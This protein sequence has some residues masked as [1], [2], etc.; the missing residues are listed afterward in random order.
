MMTKLYRFLSGTLRGRLILGVALVNAAMMALLIFDLTARQR[1]MLLNRQVEEAMALSHALALSAAGWIASDDISGL[2]ELVEA[3]RRYPEIIFALLAD[4]DGRIMADTDNRRIGQ[5]L[6]D[7]PDEKRQKIIS[8]SALL[9]DVVTPAMIGGQHVGWARVGIGQ[10]VAAAKLAR[11]TR[12][13]IIYAFG[14]ILFGSL[15]AWFLGVRVTS[16]LYAVQ[17]TIDAVRGG[18]RQA[19]SS[20]RGDDEAAVM[21]REF[22]AMLDALASRDGELRSSEERFR[23]LA[24]NARDAIYRMSLPDGR[25]EYMSPA[26]R[27]VFGHAPEEFYAEPSL[28]RTIVHPDWHAYFDDQWTRL[29]G[30]EMPPTYEYLI[31]HPDGEQHWLNQRNILVRDDHGGIVAIE[32]VVTDITARKR[33]E[34]ELMKLFIA[35]EQSPVSIVITDR[36]GNI[37]F[38]NARFVQLT[39]YGREEVLGKNTRMFK[40][41]ETPPSVYRGLWKTLADGRVWQ[42]EFHNR[43][44]NGELF[45]EAAT[46]SPMKNLDGAITHYIAIK[47]DVTERKKLEVQLLQAQKMEAVGILAGGVAHDFNN[48]L[49]AII[50]FGS[51]LEMKMSA[52]DPL[53]HN[54]TQIL[55]AA[56]RAAN[57][58]RSLLAFSRKQ[59]IEMKV[60]DLNGIVTGLEKMLRRLIREDIELTISLLGGGMPVLVDAGQI[61]QVIINLVV[62]ARDAMPAG[63]K[64]TVTVGRTALDDEFSHL[65]GYGEPG[66]YA[67]L[68]IADTG[69]GMAEEVCSRVFD[70]FFTTKEVGKGTGLGLS[71]C[72]GIVKQH[73]GYINCYSELGRGTIFRIYLPLSGV[74]AE[75]VA[76]AET[77]PLRGGT[78]TILL[79]EDD[80]FVRE[81]TRNILGEF[82]YRVLEACD[83]EDAVE[84]F[85][86]MGAGIDLCLFD[87]IMPK[88]K[89]VEAFTRIRGLRGDARVLFMSGYQSD[90]V[91]LDDLAKSG[92]GFIAK[93]V[94]PRELLR[95]I[96]E[97]LDE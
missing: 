27:E 73:G 81:L 96:R 33:T 10:K 86:Q 69:T 48:I 38:V 39:G 20:L 90:I 49:T 16:R 72:Y 71:V 58:T 63:G 15:V 28:L 3:Q 18:D 83:G 6:Q 70:P 36:G 44:K 41:G 17:R 46:I 26:A 74:E 92:A 79:A 60:T 23:R 25:Y 67:L 4:H 78:E 19:R 43:K 62:N 94:V 88:M 42:G 93:P 22:N 80:P 13:G 76:V 8:R 30:G 45:W 2:Q 87:V 89:G 29:L 77:L 52:D 64:L 57:L 68:V 51:I 7:L 82:G 40:S 1:A 54:V 55:A 35:V 84:K 24:E 34:E 5:Y 75:E 59:S 65:H 47:E 9:V 31:V 53:R 61:E 56:D 14:A 95:K 37:E 97:L 12:S 50:G 85:R 32:G 11:I 21:A 91:R 66:D